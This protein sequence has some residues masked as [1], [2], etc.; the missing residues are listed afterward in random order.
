MPPVKIAKETVKVAKGKLVR[1]NQKLKAPTSQKTKVVPRLNKHKPMKEKY[2]CGAFHEGKRRFLACDGIRLFDPK[3]NKKMVLIPGV[4]MMPS[5]VMQIAWEL[6][7]SLYTDIGF[8]EAL[9]NLG[10]Q[11][12]NKPGQVVMR[13]NST[14]LNAIDSK[15][16]K[17][18]KILGKER[19][20]FLKTF[21]NSLNFPKNSFKC[22]E[23]SSSAHCG[24]LKLMRDG[25]NVVVVKKLFL[26]PNQVVALNK[27]LKLPIGNLSLLHSDH[28]INR[29]QKGEAGSVVVSLS[30]A[31]FIYAKYDVI[32]KTIGSEGAKRFYDC[33]VENQKIKKGWWDS[34][35]G[36]LTPSKVYRG[37]MHLFET[38]LVFGVILGYVQRKKPPPGMPGGGNSG[39]ENSSSPENGNYKRL[40]WEP[41]KQAAAASLTLA[42]VA[43]HKVGHTQKLTMQSSARASSIAFGGA[44]VATGVVAKEVVKKAAKIGFWAT[45]AA[46]AVSVFSKVKTIAVGAARVLPNLMLRAGNAAA[47]GVLPPVFIIP[48]E[49][50]S[51]EG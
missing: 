9:Y 43:T 19:F 6:N 51:H 45:L 26:T 38:F 22:T 42:T 41:S 30:Y 8:R 27:A 7:L 2:T 37:V 21:I 31:K 1:P 49:F 32:E 14:I 33:F 13:I 20:S 29:L 40:L 36:D 39:G 28:N 23:G 3:S 50:Q 46:G 47:N 48:E 18:L 25:N 17:L 15:K 5:E 4:K 44:A 16:A 12:D 24:K 35:K 11:T 34:I 10:E